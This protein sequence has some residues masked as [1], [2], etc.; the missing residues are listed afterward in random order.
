MNHDNYE[1]KQRLAELEIQ[2]LQAE[3]KL[4]NTQEEC[5]ALKKKIACIVFGFG[6]LIVFIIAPSGEPSGDWFNY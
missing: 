5:E 3:T 6:L 4:K 2:L 1:E